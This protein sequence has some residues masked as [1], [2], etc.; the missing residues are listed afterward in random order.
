M[1]KKI[2]RILLILCTLSTTFLGICDAE[3]AKRKSVRPY[4]PAEQRMLDETNKKYDTMVGWSAGSSLSGEVSDS[5]MLMTEE[6]MIGA[7]RKFDYW[8]PLFTDKQYARNTRWGNIIA[9]PFTTGTAVGSGNSMALLVTNP[10]VGALKILDGVGYGTFTVEW[11]KP[12]RPGD[13]FRAWNRRPSIEDI[14]DG[15]GPRTFLITKKTDMINQKDELVSTSTN[16]V[17]ATFYTD[18]NVN[19]NAWPPLVIKELHKYTDEE[20]SLVEK[21][22]DEEEIRGSKIRYWEDVKVG[23]RPTPVVTGP[24]TVMDTL[25]STGSAIDQPMREMRKSGGMGVLVDPETNIPHMMSE[26]HYGPLNSKEGGDHQGIHY[27]TY[28]RNHLAR[29]VTNWMGDDGFLKKLHWQLF[30]YG[31]EL[32]RDVEFLKGRKTAGHDKIGD[33]LI[34]NGIVTDKRIEEGEHLV[35]LLV[36]IEDIDGD[37]GTAATVTV[38]LLS[39]E[40][41][42]MEWMK[43]QR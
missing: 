40:E 30:Q 23:D 16:Y 31:I 42:Y 41:P 24:T 15:D 19:I 27:N 4:T 8:N 43:D 33:V 26:G 22:E 1:R 7:N 11:Y 32:T 21:M 28:S 6:D 12:I 10:D 2:N 20:L 5:E 37:I 29:L 14:T 39:K 35:D 3:D 17:K 13:S 38:R 34:G 25:Y 18:P 9:A 36:W